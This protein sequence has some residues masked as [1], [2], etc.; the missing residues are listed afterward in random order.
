MR[1][2]DEV[3]DGPGF[4][5]SCLVMSLNLMYDSMY[6]KVLVPQRAGGNVH[7]DPACVRACVRAC[8]RACVRVCERACVRRPAA[9]ANLNL[10]TGACVRV[11]VRACVRRPAAG[12]TL[13]LPTA[14]GRT[15]LYDDSRA[16]HAQ[17]CR[18]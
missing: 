17:R 13:N 12:A 15:L 10:P 11:C 2:V 1:W 5:L 16:Q 14:H 6:C 9:G 7:P 3:Y 4:D 8:M 18:S